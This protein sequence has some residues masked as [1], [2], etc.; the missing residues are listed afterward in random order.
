M[1]KG[2]VDSIELEYNIRPCTPALRRE[3][4]SVFPDLTQQDVNIII[5]F[6]DSKLDLTSTNFSW[7]NK[8]VCLE[9]VIYIQ[10]FKFAESLGENLGNFWWD[11][12]D[13]C[14][15]LPVRGT[16]GPSIYD[17][18]DACQRLLGMSMI[19]VG[20]CN[21]LSHPVFGTRCYPASILTTAPISLIKSAIERFTESV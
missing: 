1:N 3:L 14:S 9:V 11:F 4:K 17:E 2:F 15:G 21:V 12:I 18:V 8:D 7:E 16:P 10:F 13:P 5:T 19:R 6:Q 20:C